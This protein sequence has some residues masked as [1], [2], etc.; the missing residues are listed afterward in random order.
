MKA[1]L[2]KWVRGKKLPCDVEAE[3]EAEAREAEA[4]EAEARE[5][6]AWEAEAQEAAAFW[7]KRKRKHLKICRFCFYSVLKLLFKFL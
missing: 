3:A 6:E 5:A 1:E 4:R 2:L 7:W